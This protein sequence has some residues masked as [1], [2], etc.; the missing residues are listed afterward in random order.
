DADK[1]AGVDINRTRWR[2]GANA[3]RKSR[4][5]VTS[6]TNQLASLAPM[7]QVWA[8][9]PP[10][11]VCSWRMAGVSVPVTWRFKTGD[12][13]PKPTLPDE[14]TNIEFVGAPAITVNGTL[15]PVMS[16]I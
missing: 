10:P 13:L 15:L 5:P 12:E 16:S 14:A 11:L 1:A 6:R 8:V 2:A 3:E 4:T 9:N 7:S